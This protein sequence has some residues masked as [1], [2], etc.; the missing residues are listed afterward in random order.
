MRRLFL[1]ALL[2]GLV[3][4]PSVYAA[5]DTAD[6]VDAHSNTVVENMVMGLSDISDGNAVDVG[7][8]G[9]IY[10]DGGSVGSGCPSAAV[11]TGAGVITRATV[12]TQTTDG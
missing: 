10:I 3:I 2:I 8:T 7:E 9:G 4:C 5:V 11:T 1:V 12:T 6:E